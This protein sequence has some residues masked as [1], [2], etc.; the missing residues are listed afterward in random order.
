M[1]SI[2]GHIMSARDL[3]RSGNFCP[4]AVN[5]DSSGGRAGQ[6]VAGGE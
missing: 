2:H 4:A 3:W 6:L 5:D 1:V